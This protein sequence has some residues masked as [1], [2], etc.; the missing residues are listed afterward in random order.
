MNEG[1]YTRDTGRSKKNIDPEKTTKKT[2]A[3]K[4]KNEASRAEYARRKLRIGKADITMTKEEKEELRRLR[5]QGRKKIYADAAASRC[6]HS[7]ISSHNEDN[8]AGVDAVNAGTEV[9]GDIGYGIRGR[10]DISQKE[11]ECQACNAKHRHNQDDSRVKRLSAYLF[12]FS[13][14]TTAFPVL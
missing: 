8:N 9:A 3:G 6:I 10:L 13:I 14:V 7:E 5:K 2:H 12:H 1:I 4:L 11:K